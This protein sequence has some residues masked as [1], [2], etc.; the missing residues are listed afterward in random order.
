MRIQ[1]R[2]HTIALSP[3]FVG[4]FRLEYSQ[5]ARDLELSRLPDCL[6]QRAV[7]S[8]G[9]PVGVH[10][11]SDGLHPAGDLHWLHG[12]A[13]ANHRHA[14]GSPQGAYSPL[15]GVAD[16]DSLSLDSAALDGRAV[17]AVNLRAGEFCPL[18]DDAAGDTR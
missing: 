14:Y 9:A 17:A 8:A 5:S 2:S 1:S 3:N 4:P 18:R 10:V 15:P 12:L 13:R 16:R 11:L 6:P 7:A